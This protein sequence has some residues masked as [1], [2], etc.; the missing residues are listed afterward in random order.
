MSG[1]DEEV[2]WSERVPFDEVVVEVVTALEH[3]MTAA[4]SM[5]TENA[6]AIVRAMEGLDWI[7]VRGKT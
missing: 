2:V 1:Q 5:H 7:V 3:K 4:A 6:L